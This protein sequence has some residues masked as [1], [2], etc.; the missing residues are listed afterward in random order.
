MNYHAETEDLLE[1]GLELSPN[2]WISN[3]YA[4]LEF[5]P[6]SVNSSAL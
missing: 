1:T 4:G 3:Y 5:V 2:A 6:Q